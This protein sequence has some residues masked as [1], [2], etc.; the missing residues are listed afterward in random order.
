MGSKVKLDDS[1]GYLSGTIQ[2][3]PKKERPQKLKDCPLLFWNATGTFAIDEIPEDMLEAASDDPME[4]YRWWDSY[5]V[6]PED[7]PTVIKPEGTTN[8]DNQY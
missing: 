7:L 3:I 8:S 2:L 6:P 4:Y 1:F 5:L